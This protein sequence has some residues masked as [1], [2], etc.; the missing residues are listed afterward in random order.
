MSFESPTP[1]TSWATIRVYNARQR[2]GERA[3]AEHVSPE[4][5]IRSGETEL[6]RWKGWDTGAWRDFT[7]AQEEHALWIAVK[8]RSEENYA[9]LEGHRDQRGPTLSEPELDVCLTLRGYN[10][11]PMVERFRLRSRGSGHDLKIEKA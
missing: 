10:I 8:V 5:V 6:F 2:G 9:A 3:K 4:I 7:T 11:E 1:Y